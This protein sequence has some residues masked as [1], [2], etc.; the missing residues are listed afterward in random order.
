MN[1]DLAA[2]AAETALR[3]A[4]P[5]R[6]NQYKVDLTKTLLRRALVSLAN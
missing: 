3:A 2:A 4:K 1:E 5:L 6:M